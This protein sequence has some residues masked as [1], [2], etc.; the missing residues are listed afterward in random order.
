MNFILYDLEATCWRG[1]PPHGVNEIIEIGAYK[2][3]EYGEVLGTF[4]K[5]IKPHVNPVLSGFCTWLTTI[6]QK[7]VDKAG[8]FPQ[9]IEE[10]K[11]WINTEEDYYL[12]SWGRFD[13]QLLRNDH[14]LHDV[15]DH[16]LKHHLDIKS[17]YQEIKGSHVKKVGLKNSIK[18]EGFEFTGVHHRAISDAENLTKIFVKFIDEWEY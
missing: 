13:I 4:D 17:Q 5:F 18:R 7:D 1:R 16:W 11:D 3:N 14:D 6:T 9:V 15:D 8:K 12:C 2:V 10:F